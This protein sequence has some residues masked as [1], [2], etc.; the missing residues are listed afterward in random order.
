MNTIAA[1]VFAGT[2][3]LLSSAVWP[4]GARAQVL[5]ASH[6]WVYQLVQ[7]SQLC[8]RYTMLPLEMLVPMWGTF[9][10]RYLRSD[11][12]NDYYAIEDISFM[13]TNGSL[14]LQISGDGLYSIG[15]EVAIIQTLSL[16]LTIGNGSGSTLCYFTNTPGPPT[17]LWPML[18]ASARQTNPPSRPYAPF[19]SLNLNAAPLREIWFATAQPFQAGI[20]NAPSN[21][22]SA[23]DL[24]SSI[25]R[26]VRRNAAL[27]ARLGI[28]PPVPDL[29][30]HDVDILSGGEIAFS[31]TQNIFSETLGQLYAGDLLSDWGRVVSSNSALI[32]AFQPSPAPSG[33]AGL[34]AVKLMDSGQTYFSVQTNFYSQKLKATISPGDLLSSSG[35][36]IRTNGQFLAAFNPAAPAANFGLAAIYAW[37]SGEYWFATATGFYDTSSNYYAAG[38]LLSDQGYVVFRNADL[39]SPFG[40]PASTNGY[41]LDA[42]YVV[43]DVA[44]LAGPAQL[45]LPLLTNSPPASLALQWTG[46]GRVFQL[47]RAASAP[48][49]YSPASFIDT[50]G[51]F[52]DPGVLTN[53]PQASYRL[54]Q[55]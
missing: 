47:E 4:C 31:M 32:A 53:Q 46:A 12:I 9:Q 28:M 2:A 19:Y 14:T 27:T 20:W 21:A 1:R 22:I 30:L 5:D 40:A 55:W 38:D 11:P 18:Q 44:T 8:Q 13:A 50:A 17:R 51:P 35:A 15:G 7:G 33:G 26:V 29:G 34:C 23:G 48:G 16:G 25:G 42:L 10:L 6:P 39:L 3:L 43:S 52:I 54:H 45:A 37:P 24:L 49:P 36:I 41:G